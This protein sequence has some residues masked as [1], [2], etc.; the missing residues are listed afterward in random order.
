MLS[1]IISLFDKWGYWGAGKLIN[2]PNNVT[3][4]NWQSQDSNPSSLAP[5]P[6]LLTTMLYFLFLLN[7]HLWEKDF[8][9]IS[10]WT[11]LSLASEKYL[12]EKS[13]SFWLFFFFPRS[14]HVCPAGFLYTVAGFSRMEPLCSVHPFPFQVPEQPHHSAA[15]CGITNQ[16]HPSP[17]LASAQPFRP[18]QNWWT[19]LCSNLISIVNLMINLIQMSRG[20]LS[21]CLNAYSSSNIH[22]SSTPLPFLEPFSRHWSTI[23]KVLV[24]FMLLIR[25]TRPLISNLVVSAPWWEGPQKII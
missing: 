2:M 10:K 4:V 18:N 25:L 11:C 13:R 15:A 24:L 19:V 23:R 21:C 14:H 3:P 6:L 1:K 12:P 17:T 20:M 16:P 5:E 8:C 9:V 7:K 22:P